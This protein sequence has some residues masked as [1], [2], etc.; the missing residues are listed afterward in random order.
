MGSVIL[1][2]GFGIHPRRRTKILVAALYF[3]FFAGYVIIGLQPSQSSASEEIVAASS[4][5]LAGQ[6]IINSIGLSTPVE[7]VRLENHTLDV[8][9]KIAGSFSEHENKT[10]LFGH[11]STVFEN[12]KNVK[13]GDVIDYNDHSY[14]IVNIEVRKKSE[15]S[16]T[17]ILKSEEIDTVILM[18][19]SGEAL[20]NDDYSHRL[21]VT[22]EVV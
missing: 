6:L 1:E 19:C 8:P 15:I 22:A 11:S 10:F 14:R 12:L 18:T 20:G 21:I 3:L 7:K 17:N 13:F 4:E 5:N 2:E 9:D 16:M